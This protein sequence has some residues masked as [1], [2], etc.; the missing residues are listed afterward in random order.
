MDCL[1]ACPAGSLLLLTPVIAK[2]NCTGTTENENYTTVSHIY[3]ININ[4]IGLINF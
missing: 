3:W 4:I 2:L 1:Y